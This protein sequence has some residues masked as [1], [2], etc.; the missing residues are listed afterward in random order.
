MNMMTETEAKLLWC[1]MARVRYTVK[2]DITRIYAEGENR[3][4]PKGS[5]RCIASACALWCWD[6]DEHGVC[7]QAGTG[8]PYRGCCGLIRR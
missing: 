7:R 5:A 3:G 4:V 1:P 8:Q 6:D 2:G